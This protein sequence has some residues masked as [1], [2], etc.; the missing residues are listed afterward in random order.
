MILRKTTAASVWP[1]SSESGPI[2]GSTERFKRIAGGLLRRTFS[3]S[4]LR[5]FHHATSLE[6]RRQQVRRPSD[7]NTYLVFDTNG[8][9]KLIEAI[10]DYAPSA[11]CGGSPFQASS[12]TLLVQYSAGITYGGV[13]YYG[14]QKTVV[15][16]AGFLN[17]LLNKGRCRPASSRSGSMCRPIWI[18]RSARAPPR[19]SPPVAATAGAGGTTG[20]NVGSIATRMPLDNHVTVR[21]FTGVAGKEWSRGRWKFCPL[22]ESVVAGDELTS[23]VQ[24]ARA[25]F[26]PQ[27]YLPITDGTTTSGV[28][29]LLYPILVSTKLSQLRVFPTKICYAPLVAPTANY[30]TQTTPAMINATIGEQKRRKEKPTVVF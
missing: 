27:L 23:A 20:G 22:D 6:T 25:V 16:A 5:G 10:F 24:N 2:W 1:E 29:N 28:P 4:G 11:M 8:V 26:E 30:I 19:P 17:A 18:S 3:P 12:K 7:S 15:T 13:T 9:K 21:K 14:F